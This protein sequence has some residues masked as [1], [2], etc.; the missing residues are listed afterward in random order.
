MTSRKIAI[1]L[2]GTWNELEDAA[3]PPDRSEA[4][5]VLRM[6]Q[7]CEVDETQHAF[8][9][10]GVGTDFRQGGVEQVRKEAGLASAPGW[11]NSLWGGLL[12]TGLTDRVLEAYGI[13]CS[14][15]R[16]GQ[17][18]RL[19]IFGFSRGA[20]AARSL[21]NFIDRVGILFDASHEASRRQ[22]EAPLAILNQVREAYAL[23]EDTDA[24]ADAELDSL[25]HRIFQ[26]DVLVRRK[27]SWQV[28]THLMGLWDTVATCGLQ[29]RQVLFRAARTEGSRERVPASVVCA[30][31]ALAA[32]EFRALFEPLMLWEPTPGSRAVE[33][34]W[35]PGSHADVGGGYAA[36]EAG[37]AVE[38]LRWIADAA[39]QQGL[40]LRMGELLAFQPAQEVLH[41]EGDATGL[42]DG[43]LRLVA[44]HMTWA[45]V[46]QIRARR[47][48]RIQLRLAMLS[49]RLALRACTD[50]PPLDGHAHANAGNVSPGASALAAIP[51]ARRHTSWRP[52][53]QDLQRLLARADR[54][55]G[56][57]AAA[58]ARNLF[59]H[60]VR[61]RLF[62][63]DG[64][65]PAQGLAKHS[66]SLRWALTVLQVD[67]VERVRELLVAAQYLEDHREPKRRAGPPLLS[68]LDMPDQCNLCCL[69]MLTVMDPASVDAA[70][71]T[72][73]QAA[74]DPQPW[75][76]SVRLVAELTSTRLRRLSALQ[77]AVP[78]TVVDRW[79]ARLEAL[80]E[81]P[82]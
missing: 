21:V 75:P 62:D 66:A 57:L 65:T 77:T 11:L 16:P 49:P 32:H 82:H 40:R 12:G 15:Y 24:R 50:A 38:P 44:G 2:D 74:V 72:L 76:Q 35:F 30:R 6:F 56:R 14:L 22:A 13:I 67:D 43:A 81:P 28:R 69:L 55:L 27:E 60:A 71:A 36:E 63:D 5:N 48:V 34:R 31:H 70:L 37:L 80:S 79:I 20:F 4:T 7:A 68:R 17:R 64:H 29:W 42:V 9:L 54:C 25:L 78:A 59:E 18:D 46:A 53:R 39:V 41:Q 58:D 23:C 10:P 47:G 19:Y 3:Q 73:E 51:P 52:Q 45:Q 8:Y 1:F 33:Q 26:T 61:Q